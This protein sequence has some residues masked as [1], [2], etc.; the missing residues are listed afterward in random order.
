M[1]GQGLCSNE[2]D[3]VA[4]A[5]A[6]IELFQGRSHAVGSFTL[7]AGATSTVV[8]AKNCGT[9]SRIALTPQTAN[10][11]A[12]VASTYIDQADVK[13]GSFTVRHA[14]NTQ[15]DRTFSYSIRG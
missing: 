5:R 7:A 4:I 8:T 9:D 13:A 6:I 11:A 14:N 12:A 10:A 3:P 1:A 2:R 15:V